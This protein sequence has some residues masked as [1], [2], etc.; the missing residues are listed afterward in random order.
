MEQKN[1]LSLTD[2][3]RLVHRLTDPERELVA[4]V[5]RI[6]PTHAEAQRYQREKELRRQQRYQQ[7]RTDR[8]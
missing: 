6:L 3:C 8:D 7:R 5:L 4:R 2:A 1:R